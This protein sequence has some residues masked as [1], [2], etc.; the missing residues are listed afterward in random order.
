[1][2]NGIN[3]SDNNE[4]I[5]ARLNGQNGVGSVVTNPIGNTN[6]YVKE[7]KYNFNDISAISNDAYYL[8]QRDQDIKQFNEI[9]LSGMN[10]TS[11]ITEVE[12]LFSQ[13]VVDPFVIDIAR[14]TEELA[15]YLSKNDEFL[16]DIEFNAL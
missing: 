11:Y 5:N 9:A 16:N 2:I 7:A 8:Y 13:G 6:P 10:D 3:N 1:M 12:S 4:L 14:D 15:E